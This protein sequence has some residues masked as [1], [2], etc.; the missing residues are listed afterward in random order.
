MLEQIPGL[1]IVKPI[2]HVPTEEAC[3]DRLMQ[4]FDDKLQ[5]KH[6]PAAN[7]SILQ[8]GKLPLHSTSLIM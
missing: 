8:N 3:E 7:W 5:V 1:V 4:L 2:L 6:A